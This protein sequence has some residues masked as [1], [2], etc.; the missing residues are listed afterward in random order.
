MDGESL[1]LGWNDIFLCYPVFE[2]ICTHLGPRDIFFLRQTTRQLFPIFETL[3]KTQWNINRQ[4]SHFFKDPIGFR[5]QMAKY[6]AIISGGFALQFL[7]RSFWK[8][9]D[10]DIYLDGS[11]AYRDPEQLGK[12]LVD[13]EEYRLVSMKT[14][15]NNGLQPYTNRLKHISQVKTYAKKLSTKKKNDTPNIRMI[16]TVNTPLHAIVGGFHQTL[17]MNII[18]W[19]FA[20][21]LHPYLNFVNRKSYQINGYDITHYEQDPCNETNEDPVVKYE[22]RGW[23]WKQE[24]G[25]NENVDSLRGGRRIGDSQTWTLPLDTTGVENGQSLLRYSFFKQEQLVPEMGVYRAHHITHVQI[26]RSCVL[27][28]TYTTSIKYFDPFAFWA[29]IEQKLDDLTHAELLKYPKNRRPVPLRVEGDTQK[30]HTH[31]YEMAG[32]EPEGW[33]FYDDHI[34]EWYEQYIQDEDRRLGTHQGSS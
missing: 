29:S 28:N 31:A 17:V 26:V 20:Y 4:L 8:D 10:L 12:Y 27:R 11:D 14:E 21:S 15:A 22:R 33:T 6:G 32:R 2:N 16:F 7:E 3:F 30:Y 19:D 13:R 1:P 24:A 23:E 25:I 9:S 5:S 18:S 34:P